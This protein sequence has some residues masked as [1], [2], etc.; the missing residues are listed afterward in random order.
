MAFAIVIDTGRNDSEEHLQWQRDYADTQ[1]TS[2]W[3]FIW[4]TLRYQLSFSINDWDWIRSY[5]PTLPKQFLLVWPTFRRGETLYQQ[6]EA[7]G[8]NTLDDSGFLYWIDHS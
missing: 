1:W 6:S 7:V 2:F 5:A 8:T 3:Q 4:D